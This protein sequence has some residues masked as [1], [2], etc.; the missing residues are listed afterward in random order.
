MSP[1]KSKYYACISL[2]SLELFVIFLASN[3]CCNIQFYKSLCLNKICP[4]SGGQK[5][6]CKQ[7]AYSSL[8]A[9]SFLNL[10]A[11][12]SLADRSQPVSQEKPWPTFS[13]AFPIRLMTPDLTV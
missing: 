8:G 9:S 1:V 6:I 10:E 4:P 11:T 3:S 12:L 13:F 7:R 5:Y 2:S